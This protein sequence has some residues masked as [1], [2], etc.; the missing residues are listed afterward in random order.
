MPQQNYTY[1]DVFPGF[2]YKRDVTQLPPGAFII[3][4]RNVII[5]DDDQATV[6]NGSVILASVSGST[7]PGKGLHTFLKS[8]GSEIMVK[9]YGTVLE[10]LHPDKGTWENLNSGYTSGQIFGFAEHVL[11]TD[12]LEYLYFGN[13]FEPYSRWSGAFDQL[14]GAYSGGESSVNVQGDFFKDDTAFSGTASSLTTTT[15]D[16]ATNIWATDLWKNYYVHITSGAQAGK[17]SKISATDANTITFATISGLSGT[18]TFEIRRLKFDDSNKVLRIGTTDVTYTGFTDKNTFSGV[19]NMPAAS[20]GDALCEAIKIF[21]SLPRGNILKVMNARM[22]IGGVRIAGS[23]SAVMG[24]QTSIHYSVIN[25]PT[26]FSFSATRAADEGGI[27]DIPVGGG[28]ITSLE[29]QE[30]VMYAFK[31][32]ATYTVTFTQDGNDLP[33]VF[34]LLGAQNVGAVNHLGTVKTDSDIFYVSKDKVIRSVKR[35]EVTD[36]ARPEQLSDRIKKFM[37]TTTVTSIAGVYFKSRVYYALKDS[38]S[39][40]NDTVLVYDFEKEA[41]YAPFYGWNMSAFTVYKGKLY[42]IQSSTPDVYELDV[43]GRFDDN[44]APYECR[45]RFSYNNYGDPAHLKDFDSI[46]AEGHISE[47]TE[48]TFTGRYNYLGGLS[49]RSTKLAGTETDYIVA[50]PDLNALGEFGLGEQPLG[51]TIGDDDAPSEVQRFRVIY[52]LIEQQFSE[53]S[54]EVSSEKAGDIWSLI[55]FGLNIEVSPE[56]EEAKH[57]AW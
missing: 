45:A 40:A 11:N 38:D 56:E 51:D 49:E 28:S 36:F 29:V 35:P 32:N 21:P 12:P 43:E 1:T 18:P 24:A 48:I 55:R 52:E 54:F 26:N 10:Y 17:I 19:S 20:D 4:S 34:P 14:D 5:G 2:H 15:I 7:V 30:D 50:N 31:E 46:Y 53:F 57:R 47:N 22:F 44:G 33:T 23:F 3:G 27:I 6:R 25:D 13:S 16:I 37:D 39:S 41:W 8:D 9:P 42:G